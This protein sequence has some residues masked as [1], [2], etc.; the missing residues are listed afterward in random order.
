[1]FR[2]LVCRCRISASISAGASLSS[3]R[4]LAP[5]QAFS[6]QSGGGAD[7]ADKILHAHDHDGG[8]AAAVDDEAF[9]VFGGEIHDLPELGAGDMSVDAAVHGYAISDEL[10]N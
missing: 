1:M 10:I 7:G 9:V 2:G 6:S 3:P 5:V 4:C 8:L